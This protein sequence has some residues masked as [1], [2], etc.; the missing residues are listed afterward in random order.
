MLIIEYHVRIWQ[1]SP[2]VSCGDTGQ[3]WMWF[4]ESN[5]YFH[6]I[7]AYGE[8]NERSLS[9]PH[10]RYHCLLELIQVTGE[11]LT[12]VTAVTVPELRR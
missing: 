3:I 9:N 11:A 6:K 4:K 12:T 1:V 7:F 10:H 8:I 5:G 2:Q